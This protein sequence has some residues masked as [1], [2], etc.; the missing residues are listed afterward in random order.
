MHPTCSWRTTSMLSGQCQHTLA[1]WKV[2]VPTTSASPFARAPLFDTFFL[3]CPIR[4]YWRTAQDI[5]LSGHVNTH[6]H[7]GKFGCQQLGR[8]LS[9]LSLTLISS[10]VRSDM[11]LA[12]R[13]DI[14]SRKCERTL[15]LWKVWVPTTS[16]SPFAPL[17][18]TFFL[19]CPIRHV[20]GEPHRMLC[21]LANVNTH[22]HCGKF[23]CQRL[24]RRLS[25]LSLTFF[26]L[27]CPIRH[28]LGGPHR[29]YVWQMSTHTRTVE[30]L[31]AND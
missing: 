11:F 24:A 10:T 25:G 26:R 1:L 30:S 3:N 16:P 20:L 23:G 12:N 19:N 22:S 17:F 13:I 31:G 9:R 15:A 28:V 7:C 29:H 21:Y 2:W 5:M 14:V 4:H 8:R 6:S 18:D 27:N